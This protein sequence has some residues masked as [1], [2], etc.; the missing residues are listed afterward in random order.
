[1]LKPV[2]PAIPKFPDA[3]F[4]QRRGPRSQFSSGILPEGRCSFAPPSSRKYGEIL[5]QDGLAGATRVVAFG[6]GK[7]DPTAQMFRFVG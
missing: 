6:V 2:Y 7:E 1:M 5:V 4:V 3:V